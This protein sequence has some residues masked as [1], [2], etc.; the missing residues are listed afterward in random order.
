[1]KILEKKFELNFDEDYW[2]WCCGVLSFCQE[3]V[4][5]LFDIP[6]GIKT[7]W[8]SLHDRPRANRVVGKVRGDREKIVAESIAWLIIDKERILDDFV[9]DE[10]LVPLID[11]T[12]YIQCEYMG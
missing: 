8:L 12:I 6:E 5:D 10:I 7:I 11:K 9:F 4:D 3:G 1:M 2:A